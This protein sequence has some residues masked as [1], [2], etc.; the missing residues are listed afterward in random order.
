MAQPSAPAGLASF[1][2]PL[3]LLWSRMS[4]P[5]N[6]VHA[7]PALCGIPPSHVADL[8]TLHVA[9]TEQAEQLLE[10]AP[11]LLRSLTCSTSIAPER[12]VG[13][14]RGPILWAE[15]LTARA[16][17]LGAEDVFVCGAPQRD[18]DTVENR[19]FVAALEL[20]AGAARRTSSPAA[21][22]SLHPQQ[23]QLITERSAA[24]QAFLAEP[25]LRP[26]RH[27]RPGARAVANAR[28]GRRA[29]QFEPAFQ[30]WARRTD[31]IHPDELLAC[32]D[33]RTRGQ[34]RAFA[35][36][37][38]TL[39]RR[40]LAVPQLRIEGSEVVAGRLRYRNWRRATAAGNHGILLD[41]VLIDG[42]PDAGSTS[43]ADALARLERR[44][45]ERLFCLVTDEVEAEVAVELALS[46]RPRIGAS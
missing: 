32:T 30:M 3:H 26:L 42:A 18:F 17:G 25:S 9:L 35:L 33:P 21:Q 24:A 7:L 20:L 12:S 11:R 31:P 34:Q 13:A 19:I 36:V 45:G 6:L 38:M 37:M 16:H 2:S 28:R 43:R 22:R 14:V 39:V 44:A 41:G 10:A 27:R 1:S 15:T 8:M 4:R 5:F 23:R 46:R 40:G 29:P